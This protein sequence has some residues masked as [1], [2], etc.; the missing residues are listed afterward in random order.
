MK[1]GT[2]SPGIDRLVL[3]AAA[4]LAMLADHVGYRFY[5][6]LPAASLLRT[7]GR[8]AFPIFAFM[9]AEGAKKSRNRQKYLLRLFIFGL[10]SEPVYDFF[11]YGKAFSLKGANVMYTLA[12]G[13]ASVI[14]YDAIH[15]C[16]A[17]KGPAAGAALKI[18]AFIPLFVFSAAAEFASADYGMY[19]VLLVF[20]YYLS[21][22][23]SA[24]GNALVAGITLIF[25]ARFLLI[26]SFRLVL[27]AV[28]SAAAPE[29]PGSWQSSQVFAAA[30][31]VLILTYNRSPGPYG[32]ENRPAAKTALKYFFY[33]FYPLH[34]LILCLI[35]V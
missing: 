11:L 23:G 3:K 15:G 16:A 12:L 35:P 2:Q 20:L 33:L 8:I 24:S 10:V 22:T 21:E 7:A 19:G 29:P 34:L 30:S 32:L 13:L 1:S 17:G 28:F 4:C 18:A 14:L 26:R 9:V 27:S 6:V 5:R 31:L 25:A